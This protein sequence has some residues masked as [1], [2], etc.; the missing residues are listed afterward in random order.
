MVMSCNLNGPQGDQ[1]TRYYAAPR[2]TNREQVVEVW[3][4]PVILLPS[5]L[6]S[7]TIS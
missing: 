1:G 7:E 4:A 2:I 3:R 6:T 5:P